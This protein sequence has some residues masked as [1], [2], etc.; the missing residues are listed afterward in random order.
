[1][2]VNVNTGLAVAIATAVPPARLRAE[3]QHFR[4]DRL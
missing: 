2:E 3:D 1:M 4:A